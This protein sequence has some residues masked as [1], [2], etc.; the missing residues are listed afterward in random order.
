MLK[1]VHHLVVLAMVC[2]QHYALTAKPVIQLGYHCIP[3]VFFQ[4]Y[5]MSITSYTIVCHHS[6]H[7][8]FASIS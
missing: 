5:C 7:L 1:T 4:V 2:D 6:C 3:V 8:P